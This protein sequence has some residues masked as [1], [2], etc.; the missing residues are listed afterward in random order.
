MN[1]IEWNLWMK[2]HHV[3]IPTNEEIEEAKKTGC[4]K[5]HPVKVNRRLEKALV[6]KFASMEAKV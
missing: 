6:D 5:V 4:A 3:Y 1:I 2:E